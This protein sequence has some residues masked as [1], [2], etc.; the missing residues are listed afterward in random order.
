MPKP[1]V[2]VIVGS[3]R[4]ESINRRY[5]KALAKLG[6][7]RFDSNFVRIDDL[8]LFNQDLEA[9]LPPEVVRYKDEIK[10]ADGVLFV[11]PEHDRSMPTVLNNAVHWGARP[12]GTSVWPGKPG[13]ITGTTPGALGTALAQAHLRSIMLGLGMTLLGGE[14][15]VTNKPGLFD[16]NGSI[17]DENTQKFLQGFVDRLATLVEKLSGKSA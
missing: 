2:A 14:A 15:Y 13:F 7:A 11:T 16:D 12:F 6:A 1:Q 17:G 9:N 8:P 10:A 4:K 5:A 3:N